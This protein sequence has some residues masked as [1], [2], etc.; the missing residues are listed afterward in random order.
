[1][2]RTMKEKIEFIDEMLH[3]VQTTENEEVSSW[4]SHTEKKHKTNQEQIIN[5]IFGKIYDTLFSKSIS[6]IKQDVLENTL[7]TLLE[8]TN[9]VSIRSKN[10]IL[11]SIPET[12][13]ILDKKNILTKLVTPSNNTQNTIEGLSVYS[14]LFSHIQNSN[15]SI[16]EILSDENVQKHTRFQS[17]KPKL[18]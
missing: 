4:F 12:Q 17:I 11:Q 5:Q 8:D 9:E 18:K 16:L 6:E 13:I 3:A 2:Y 1:M 15:N 14:E 7:Y 10:Q